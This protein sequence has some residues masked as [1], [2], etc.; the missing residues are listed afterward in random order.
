MATDNFTTYSIY[1]IVCFVTGKCYV[2]QTKEPERRR[3]DHFKRL[4]QNT[5]INK[6]LQ[7]AYNAHG[8]QSFY[9]E[10]L[11]QDISPTEVAS[12]EQNWIAY[13]DSCHNGF[14]ATPGGDF[15]PSKHGKRTGNI[16]TWKDIEYL[17]VS[18]AARAIGISSSAMQK[19]LRNGYTTE[20]DVPHRKDLG[21]PCTW[22]SVEYPTV[23]AAAEANNVS[24]KAMWERIRCGFTSD[25]EIRNIPCVWN[26]VLYSSISKAA[27]ALGLTY[28]PM[29]KRIMKGYTCDEDM[30]RKPYKKS[31][32]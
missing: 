13:F 28:A 8:L 27:K 1:R 26:G 18:E 5:H 9:F 2:G 25:D 24:H 30:K 11:E 3:R 16:I 23:I 7:N 22:N 31:N 4:A 21:K 32:P 10:I 15:E 12:R 17:S 19:R 14:N 29:Y 6:H 20:N